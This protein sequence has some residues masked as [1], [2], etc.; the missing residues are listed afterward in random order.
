MNEWPHTYSPSL[1][2]MH[3]LSPNLDHIIQITTLDQP[4]KSGDHLIP[5]KGQLFTTLHASYPVTLPRWK[6]FFPQLKLKLVP[7]PGL[8]KGCAF[9]LSHV[10]APFHLSI[11]SAITCLGVPSGPSGLGQVSLLNTLPEPHLYFTV[12][13]STCLSCQ[14]VCSRTEGGMSL[15]GQ[16]WIPI[17][18]RSTCLVSKTL[19]SECVNHAL[20]TVTELSSW[21]QTG[22]SYGSKL[23][24]K[25]IGIVEWK[26]K[27]HEMI[28]GVGPTYSEWFF[29]MKDSTL[30][31]G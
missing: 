9:C 31:L 4:S 23:T 15:A 29:Y 27:N 21:P 20:I 22:N 14:T 3:R 5:V 13:I 8:C 19:V 1:T 25:Y 16:Q 18:Q 26:F 28:Q 24:H 2:P 6:P 30:L 12:R 17:I 11:N 10:P 7:P